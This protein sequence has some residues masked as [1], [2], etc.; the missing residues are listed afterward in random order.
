M[1]IRKFTSTLVAANCYVVSVQGT[2]IVIDPMLESEIILD[3]LRQNQLRPAAVINTHG[4]AD[5][6]AGNR[7]LHEQTG[8]PV[9]IHEA[10]AVYL[11]DPHLNLSALVTAGQPITSPA[12]QRLLQDGDQIGLGAEALTVIHT[13]GHSPGSICLY[14]PGVLFTG[15]TLFKLSIGRSDFPGGD[16]KVLKKSLEK[17]K[18]LPPETG[19]YP[20][21]GPDILLEKALVLNPFLR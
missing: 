15:D 13:P 3:Y 5:H 6:I 7:I 10:D 4:H 2:A 9:Y 8:A 14:S 17:I 19:V 16:G 11:Q 18:Q 12:P 20:G 1:E 21:H